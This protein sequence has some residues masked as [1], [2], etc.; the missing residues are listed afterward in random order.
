MSR[1]K[2]TSF[3]DRRQLLRVGGAMSVLGVAAPFAMQLAA[4]GSAAG[5]S[6]PDYKALV[7]VFLF[8]GNDA[9]N[10]VLATDND[11]WTRYFTARNTGSDPIALM[12]VGTAPTPVGQV[13]AIT[14]RVSDAQSPE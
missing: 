9:N 12:P 11:T 1:Y 8:G 13:N 14:G 2:G 10:M 6:A 5:Q 4:A 7:C 3:V